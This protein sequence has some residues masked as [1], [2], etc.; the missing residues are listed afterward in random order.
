MPSPNCP[1][2][3]SPQ[4]HVDRSER[5]VQACDGPGSR[6]GGVGDRAATGGPDDRHRGRVIRRGVVADL[7][8]R[9]VAPAPEAAGCA[10]GTRVLVAEGDGLDSGQGARTADADDLD[11]CRSVGGGVVAEL[12]FV[13]QPPAPDAAAR[14]DGA[15]MLQSQ[16]DV[17]D[18]GEGS[19]A[20]GADDLDGCRSVGGGVVA[21]LAF[22]V[23]A[24][25]PG[26]AVGLGGAGVFLAGSE[27]GDGGEGS[28][29]AGSVDLDGGELV[30]GGVVSELA[31]V[32]SAPAPGG[33]VGLGGA[34]VGFAG[35]GG[36]DGGEGSGAAGALDL[37]RHR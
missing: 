10:E 33:A 6:P 19:G 23:V 20:A 12:A 9:V 30:G 21:E 8:L 31:F 35:C 34:D 25:A 24:P 14:T 28:G 36:G 22:G 7:A 26:G 37:D 27:V 1:S 3:L 2:A 15:G 16:I 4:H 18:A 11:G 13:V 5:M 32:V 17:R 29:S